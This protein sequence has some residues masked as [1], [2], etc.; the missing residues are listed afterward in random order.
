MP[1]Q[2]VPLLTSPCAPDQA[3]HIGPERI[4]PDLIGHMEGWPLPA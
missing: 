4:G 1:Q 2:S 3:M